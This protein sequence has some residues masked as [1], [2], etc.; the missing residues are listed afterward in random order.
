MAKVSEGKTV[1]HS[2]D[3]ACLASLVGRSFQASFGD[4]CC[5]TC[6]RVMEFVHFWFRSKAH[7]H[8][9]TQKFDILI[10]LRSATAPQVH[11]DMFTCNKKQVPCE[12]RLP[13]TSIVDLAAYLHC[14]AARATFLLG[15]AEGDGPT[16]SKHK[17]TCIKSPE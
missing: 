9:K 17:G 13:S 2:S 6:Y 14:C 11:L 3:A 10:R 15:G 7:P 8:G 5:Q 1:S 4:A 12:S 16:A